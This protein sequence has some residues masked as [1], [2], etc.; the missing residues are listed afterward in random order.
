MLFFLTN[1]LTCFPF[2][3]SFRPHQLPIFS[4]VSI[5]IHSVSPF[6]L[7]SS[8][9]SSFPLSFC[10]PFLLPPSTLLSP[11]SS[12]SPFYF[13]F[14]NFLISL[15]PLRELEPHSEFSPHPTDGKEWIRQNKTPALGGDGRLLSRLLWCCQARFTQYVHSESQR[16]PNRS[17]P[18]PL[19]LC[20]K[21]T[22]SCHWHL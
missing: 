3:V 2:F 11:S 14:L 15:V 12:P 19:K 1:W 7:P 16:Y 6:L 18:P 21:K 10:S 22:P 20:F 17:P 13:Y 9:P 4:S 8:L 5:C